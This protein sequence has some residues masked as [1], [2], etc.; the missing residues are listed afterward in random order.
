M[1]GSKTGGTIAVKNNKLISFYNEL[2]K[3]LLW[4]R[5]GKL[6]LKVSRIKAALEGPVRTY[7]DTRDKLIDEL[8]VWIPA[9]EGKPKKRA[10]KPHDD[11]PTVEVWDFGA[12]EEEFENRNKELEEA[13]TEITVPAFL[14]D[15]DLDRFEKDRIE[16]PVGADGKAISGV[17]FMLLMPVFESEQ[18]KPDKGEKAAAKSDEAGDE[19]DD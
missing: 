10:K 19:K 15:D 7:S 17:D 4:L 12:N 8:V 11:I 9:K 5:P 2:A 1:A 3:L 6:S 14:T 16:K 18:P 13:T